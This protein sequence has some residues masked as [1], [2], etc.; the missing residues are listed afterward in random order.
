MRRAMPAEPS[1]C[2]HLCSE[3]IPGFA[4][5]PKDILEWDDGPITAAVRCSKCDACALLELVDRDASHRIRTFAMRPLSRAALEL[6]LRDLE[7]GSCDPSRLEAER[8]A[9]LCAAGAPA[10]TVAY[11]VD[12]R[13]L[14]KQ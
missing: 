1:L 10:R 11:D 5:Q 9:L 6:Y 13:T 8:H 3:E 7:R 4:I 2:E 14:V 12:A